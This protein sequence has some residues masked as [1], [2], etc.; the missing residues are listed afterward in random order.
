MSLYS[1][2]LRQR[3]SKERHWNG[4]EDVL[5]EFVVQICAESGVTLSV[6]FSRASG[7]SIQGAIIL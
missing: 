1:V 3:I 4:V 7:L 2:F 6:G 5:L